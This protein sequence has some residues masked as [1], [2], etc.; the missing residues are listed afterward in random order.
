VVRK[1]EGN[2]ALLREINTKPD[3]PE[4][5]ERIAKH[6]ATIPEEQVVQIDE[7]LLYTS[8]RGSRLVKNQQ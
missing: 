8:K 2:T 6:R 5:L 3:R 1:S 4:N 7:G